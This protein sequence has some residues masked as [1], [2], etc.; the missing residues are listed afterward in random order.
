LKNKK[1]FAFGLH[2]FFAWCCV[3]MAPHALAADTFEISPLPLAQNAKPKPDEKPEQAYA[4]QLREINVRMNVLIGSRDYDSIEKMAQGWQAQYKAKALSANDYF[5]ALENI[6]PTLAGKGMI[7]D[8]VRWTRARPDS[9]FAWYT[10]GTQYLSIAKSEGSCGCN[11]DATAEQRASSA[12]YA[13]QAHD[14]FLQSLKLGTDPTPSY[15]QLIIVAAL[16]R[17]A[18][19]SLVETV[20]MQVLQ[21][22][23]R[24]FCPAQGSATTLFATSFE[25]GLYYLCLSLKRDPEATL[26]FEH[27]V[28]YNSPRWYGDDNILTRLLAEIERTQH[29]SPEAAGVMRAALL[30]SQG[31]DAVDLYHQPAL[32]AKL[33]VQAFDAWPAPQHLDW[34]YRAANTE[35]LTVKNK[36]YARVIFNKIIAYRPGEATAIAGIGWLDEDRGDFKGYMNGMIAAGNLGLFEAQN[37]IG[38]YYMVGQR[39]L[40]RDLRQAKAWLTLAA[41]QGFAHAREKL[42]VVDAM[43]AQEAKR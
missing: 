22:P 10:L 17:R 24:P 13:G 26:P 21:S 2:T 29:L 36:E 5:N 14:A 27:F 31:A 20:K 23:Q 16:V 35:N 32:A 41:N 12:N 7:G 1:L 6:A 34:L 18:D 42:A 43:I 25:E 11:G 39:G 15:S 8:L 4:R 9:Y 33:Y 38:Y 3:A 28:T 40:P 37:N 30:E 19:L